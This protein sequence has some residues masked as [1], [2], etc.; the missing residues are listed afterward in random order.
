VTEFEMVTVFND[1]QLAIVAQLS[2]YASIMSGFLIMSFLAAHRLSRAMVVIAIS[3]FSW[4]WYVLLMLSYREMAGFSGLMGEMRKFKDAGRGL[5]WHAA[6]YTP[7]FLLNIIPT[8]WIVFQLIFFVA[9]VGFFFH[10][11]RENTVAEVKATFSG[12]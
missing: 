12:A 2:L 5:H 1:M 6:A 8:S 7:T 11:R 9:A 3:L 10:C 4:L